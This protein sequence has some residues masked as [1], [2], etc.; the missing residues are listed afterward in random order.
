MFVCFRKLVYTI[1]ILHASGLIE[2]VGL[3]VQL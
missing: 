3:K 1:W 2:V